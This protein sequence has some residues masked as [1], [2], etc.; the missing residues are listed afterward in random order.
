MKLPRFSL[1]ELFLLIV[2]AAMGCGWWR[3]SNSQRETERLY[4]WPKQSGDKLKVWV[5]EAG[6]EHLELGGGGVIDMPQ[7]IPGLVIQ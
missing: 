3:A 2:I 6:V 5:D 4:L 7:D 1:R